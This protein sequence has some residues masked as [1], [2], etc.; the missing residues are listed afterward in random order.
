MLALK[1]WMDFSS[2]FMDIS[3]V[4]VSEFNLPLS[5]CYCKMWNLSLIGV[6]AAPILEDVV[7]TGLQHEI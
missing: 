2:S 5:I 4:N 1:L 6:D 7:L 3:L